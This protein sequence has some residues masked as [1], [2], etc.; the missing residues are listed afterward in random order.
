MPGIGKLKGPPGVD[1]VPPGWRIRARGHLLKGL[2]KP[3]LW[4]LNLRISGSVGLRWGLGLC[5]SST[6]PSDVDVLVLGTH[7]KDHWH[8]RIFPIALYDTVRGKKKK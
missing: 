3:R 1:N 6:F 2:L 7:F 5:V 4:G 8:R